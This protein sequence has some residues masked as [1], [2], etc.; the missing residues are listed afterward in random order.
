MAKPYDRPH[1]VVRTSPLTQGFTSVSAGGGRAKR[2]D[3]DP[4][5]H[6]KK[7]E[8]QFEHAVGDADDTGRPVR[9]EFQSEAGFD[10]QLKS[11]D[12][13][14]ENG[15]ELLAVRQD[16]DVTFAT[17]L[18]PADQLKRFRKTFEQ[19][20]NEQTKAGTPRHAALLN[21]V[22]AIRR[23][24]LKS[25]WTELEC[26][27]PD[28]DE[29]AWFEIW[30]RRRGTD[31]QVF[32]Q[33]ARS[34]GLERVDSKLTFIDRTVLVVGGTA[35]Q[36]EDLLEEDSSVAEVR[37]A[38][39]LA[40]DFTEM[41]GYDQVQWV[42]ELLERLKVPDAEA[43]AVC[44]LD[45]G[46]NRG[47]QLLGP[48]V[49]PEDVHAYDPKWRSDDHQG[50]GTELAGTALYG[51]LAAHLAGRHHVVLKHRL[52]SVKILPPD[53]ENDP[54]LWGAITDE[55]VARAEVAAPD[56]ARTICLAVTSKA[57]SDQ[58]RPS[59]WSAALDK[60]AAGYNG[61]DPK[62]V[63]VSAGN[64]DLDDFIAYPS[65]NESQGVFD[66]AQ[67]WNVL[68]VGAVAN[69][70][71]I[72]ENNLQGWRPVADN[73][74][75]GPSS[76]TSVSWNARASWPLKPDIL[77][78]GGNAAVDPA[79]KD[80]DT[81]DSLGL[82]TTHRQVIGRQLSV[83]RD[84]SAA[85]ALAAR[86]AARL[87]AEYPTYWPETI[88]A[89][90]VHSAEWTPQMLARYPGT[91]RAEVERRLRCCGYG[92]PNEPAA[93]A[94]AAN[95]ATV[96]I[97][98]QLQPFGE[99]KQDGQRTIVTQDLHLHELP[100]P[101]DALAALGG[102]P[103]KMRVTLSYFIEPSPGERGSA[104][105]YRYGSFGL[106]FDLKTPTESDP[107][108]TK[109][110]NRQAR[111]EDG[112]STSKSDSDRWVLGPDLRAKGSVHS[113]TWEG[114]ATELAS[115]G[116]VAVFPAIGWW[117]ERHHLGRWSEKARYSL[118]ISIQARELDVDVYTPI[119]N[120]IG[121]PIPVTVS[122]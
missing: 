46:V 83:T 62:V 15:I 32:E 117:K 42:N 27:I 3:R 110:I 119:K 10:L 7:L 92:V 20:I 50:H 111:E 54:R 21:S 68:T 67:A 14:K 113:D 30:L 37:L 73:G 2:K 33:A 89:L 29:H 16:G 38:R 80:I 17:V 118:I 55:S 41:T 61:G 99:R 52:E 84:T 66:P 44:L 112:A 106:R 40:S 120:L 70:T 11:L 116:L 102:A 60:L 28:A 64:V 95:D 91:K 75:L 35:K 43:P 8:K 107:D 5:I 114:S 79:G 81:P 45:T 121:V 22:A 94:S 101:K 88:R 90:I 74:D 105:S 34:V 13:S 26:G 57:A 9:V 98:Q 48:A 100:W 78:D 18:I 122:R 36:L 19:Y 86:L 1:L 69:R 23:A 96:V 12:S 109:R 56:R 93:F 103:L 115:K 87:Q 108:F 24:A 104:S 82:L 6:G 76:S 85:T 47:H 53:G 72:T 59:S 25:V 65:S 4:S 77:M 39:V 49:R 63:C 71:R 58:G 51:D 31:V 97:Q